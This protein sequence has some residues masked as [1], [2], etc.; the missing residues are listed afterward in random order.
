MK[1]RNHLKQG[2]YV[3]KADGT[4]TVFPGDSADYVPSIQ[5]P[6][7]VITVPSGALS[8]QEAALG[9]D[10]ASDPSET[11]PE[12]P[13]VFSNSMGNSVTVGV[14]IPADATIK[15]VVVVRKA[16]A[17][18]TAGDINDGVIVKRILGSELVYNATFEFSDT[19]PSGWYTYTAFT[20]DEF[21]LWGNYDYDWT[22]VG[23]PIITN[24]S[25]SWSEGVQFD[26]INP[27]LP[28]PVPN[29]EDNNPG[30][31]LR[32]F[33]LPGTTV[34]TIDSDG[35]PTN[36]GNLEF[37]GNWSSAAIGQSA[38]I[39]GGLPSG[40]WTVA[41][42]AQGFDPARPLDQNPTGFWNTVGVTI[43]FVQP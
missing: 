30:V 39:Y 27:V 32:V 12:G 37:D 14:H 21:G 13:G 24:L 23:L 33:S 35:N 6:A 2:V 16:G 34:P 18:N 7:K 11:I 41:I 15:E 3:T 9:G 42:F 4:S 22:T 28:G 1:L 19:P 10:L 43:T 20:Y 5:A 36:G 38:Y 31:H 8:P 25:L 17:N 40:T 26:F 29:N